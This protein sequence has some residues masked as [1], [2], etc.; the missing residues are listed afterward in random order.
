MALT[1][2]VAHFRSVRTLPSARQFVRRAKPYSTG[3]RTAAS[4]VLDNLWLRGSSRL[5]AAL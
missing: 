3:A 5:R 4:A 1:R 2:E